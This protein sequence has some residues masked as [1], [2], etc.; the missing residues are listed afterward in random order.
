MKLEIGKK[1]IKR[2]GE[3]LG[4][5]VAND[6]CNTRAGYPFKDERGYSYRADGVLYS[7]A[8]SPEDIVA[9]Y[10]EPLKLEVGK[11]YLN[12]LNEQRTI[13]SYGATDKV[14]YD[15]AGCCYWNNGRTNSDSET[16]RDLV[17]EYVKPALTLPLYVNQVCRTRSGLKARVVCIDVKQINCPDYIAV[18]IADSNG[19]EYVSS[20]TAIGTYYQSPANTHKNDLVSDYTEETFTITTSQ[21]ITA[22]SESAACAEAVRQLKESAGDM[23]SVVKL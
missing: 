19:A 4:P 11:T 8:G 15:T 18:I 6:N 10:V 3:I 23:L 20:L 21:T 1:Y 13:R 22:E 14:V 2:N 16:A 5:L 7:V 17:S 12:R 9:E